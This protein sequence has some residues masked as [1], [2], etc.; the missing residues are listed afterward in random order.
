MERYPS[1]TDTSI[2]FASLY[3]QVLL[4]IAQHFC[5]DSLTC[6]ACRLDLLKDEFRN[7]P[8]GHITNVFKDQ[9]TLFRTYI[10]LE[11]QVRSYNHIARAYA[12]PAKPRNKRGIELVLIERG[13]QLPKE[14]R[15]AKKKIENEAGK[16]EYLLQICDSGSFYIY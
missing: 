13:S 2:S 12:K 9:K 14:L 4:R 8:V 1:S 6:L 7:V 15:A 16:C 5:P 3:A 10:V 11:R